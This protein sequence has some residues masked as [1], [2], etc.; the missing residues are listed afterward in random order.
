MILGQTGGIPTLRRVG[1][2]ARVLRE[3]ER[4]REDDDGREGSEFEMSLG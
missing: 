2:I 3:E 4:G 1:A